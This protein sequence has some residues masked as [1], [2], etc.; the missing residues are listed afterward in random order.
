MQ[1]LIMSFIIRS[2][3]GQASP[4]ASFHF[5]ESCGFASNL[6]SGDRSFLPANRD[7]MHD[8]VSELHWQENALSA[9]RRGGNVCSFMNSGMVKKSPH[10][11]GWWLMCRDAIA[12]VV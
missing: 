2:K 10:K 12:N 11:A 5:L 7:S 3:F 4:F 8:G 9:S 6:R 1:R